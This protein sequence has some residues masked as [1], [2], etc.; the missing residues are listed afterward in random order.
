MTERLF[1][2]DSLMKTCAARV[3]SCTEEKG[4]Y[5][6][7]LD[8]TVFFPEGGGQL[9]DKGIL[10]GIKVE[11]VSEREGRIFHECA[12]PLNAGD[13]VKA[14]IDWK[15]RLDRMQQHLGEHLLSYACWKLF[16]ANNIGFHMNEEMVTIDLD[17][18]LTQEELE[19]A[20][21]FTNEII[22][23]NRP[24]SV[25]YMDST[26]AAKLPMRKFNK[27]IT[28]TLRLV[29]VKDADICTCCGTHP[30]FTGMLGAVKIIRYER[31]KQGQRIEFLCGMRAL[32]DA[33]LKNKLILTAGAE[34]SSKPEDVPQRILKLKEE[35]A[36][37]NEELKGKSTALLAVKLDAAAAKARTKNGRRLLVVTDSDQKAAKLLLPLAEAMEKTVSV[38]FTTGERLGYTVVLGKNT[39]GDCRNLIKVLNEEFSGRGGGKPDCAQG[40][41][42]YVN[43]WEEKLLSA[44]E[45][46]LEL[47]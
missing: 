15:V 43:G 25:D 18:E 35:I 2:M 3:I 31:H 30:P 6:V 37:L 9:S 29:S 12:A 16:S 45:K 40:G 42:N 34:L 26:E 38:I 24:V 23:E 21:L 13:T 22:W 5:L 1:E 11:H 28:G 17:K 41:A 27:K 36:S 14:E 46:M 7:E 47:F 39:E 19:K 4:K 8:R 33:A 20:E 32:K 44:E 10:G